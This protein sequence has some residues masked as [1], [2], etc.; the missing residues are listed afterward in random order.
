MPQTIRTLIVDDERY[1]RDE[2]HFLLSQHECIDIIG[3]AETGEACI[4][5]AIQ[6][7]PD[8]V[9]LDIEMPIM[10]GMKAADSLKELRKVPFIV[11][12]TAHPQF[13]AEAFRYEAIDYLLKPYDEEQLQQTI[14]R[15]QQRLI[16][17]SPQVPVPT[18]KLPVEADGD[19]YYLDPADILYIYRDDKLSRIVSKKGRFEVKT[20][21]KEL[22]VR[23][24][25]F[26][27][28]RIH[29]SYLVNLRCVT[30]LSPWFNGAFQ[31]EVEG[32]KEQLSVSRNYVKELKKRLEL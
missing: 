26:S 3:E 4:V 28:F 23:L 31:L 8:L 2:L 5:K 11:F 10:N 25:P 20:P 21:L 6:L 12:A 7:Q 19:I 13:A 24:V 17:D 18:G 27:F 29:K 1:N 32:Q 22:E 30:R 14:S 9:F 16:A 15:I